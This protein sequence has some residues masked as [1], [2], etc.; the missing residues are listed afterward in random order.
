MQFNGLN[1]TPQ[2]TDI[3]DSEARECTNCDLTE[4]I[5]YFQSP[6]SFSTPVVFVGKTYTIDDSTG[7][8]LENGN[9]FYTDRPSSAPTLTEAS[10]GSVPAGTYDILITYEKDGSESRGSEAST[11]TLSTSDKKV[12][13][14]WSTG[15]VPTGWNVNIYARGGATYIGDYVLLQTILSGTTDYTNGYW[16]WENEPLDPE[17]G[18]YDAVDNYTPPENGSTLWIHNS[19]LFVPKSE[20]LY[21]SKVEQ[22]FAFPAA[23]DYPF[24]DDI[25]GITSARGELII[26]TENSI[27]RI[28]GYN[29]DDF[30]KIKTPARKGCTRINTFIT[31]KGNVVFVADDGLYEFN[32]MGVNKLSEK[33]NSLFSSIPSGIYA[34]WDGR[35]YYLSNGIMLDAL[36]GNW[37][38]FDANE[39]W[40]YKTKEFLY[41]L[42]PHKVSRIMID[43]VGDLTL[44]IYHNGTLRKT[45]NFNA[46][47]RTIPPMIRY[48][49]PKRFERIQLRFTGNDKNTVLYAWS[50]MP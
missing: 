32:G 4:G 2:A 40:V 42:L 27:Y 3:S 47:T 20:H 13:I 46:S 37:I 10:G 48:L 34:K 36:R 39:R 41:N 5:A 19:I 14:E 18:I 38:Q 43:F 1:L 30:R 12:K 6:T 49:P 21:F 29:E 16:D 23:N 25:T 28:V 7:K 33:V 11:I 24:D 35:Y 26:S 31:V 8:V 15:D 9:E 22:L 17:M 44:E 45:Y 50:F